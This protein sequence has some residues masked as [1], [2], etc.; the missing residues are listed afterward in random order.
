[1]IDNLMSGRGGWLILVF[2][3]FPEAIDPEAWNQI[4]GKETR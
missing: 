3:L 2:L 4:H 1:M